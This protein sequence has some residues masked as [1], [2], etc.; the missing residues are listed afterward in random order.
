MNISIKTHN[1][2][3]TPNIRTYA[4][5]KARAVRKVLG[6]HNESDISCDIL[7][8]HDDKHATGL[9]YRAD[10]SIFAGGER[11]H[12]VGHGASINAAIDIAKDELVRRTSREKN[13]AL[14]LLKRG[15]ARI[16]SWLRRENT[17][18]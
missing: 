10:Y 15:G 2:D 4:E 6:N 12:A 7:L 1:L 3:L 5:E 13:R 16:K 14:A 11:L 9:V 18:L 8:S 17:E